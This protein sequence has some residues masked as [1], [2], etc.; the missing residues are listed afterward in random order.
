M[1]STT[2][3]SISSLLLREPAL[4]TEGTGQ[5][6]LLP[7]EVVV[8]LAGV[9]CF[10]SREQSAHGNNPNVAAAGESKKS[11]AKRTSMIASPLIWEIERADEMSMRRY[12]LVI[13]L[14]DK[15]NVK[16]LMEAV[17]CIWFVDH[18]MRFAPSCMHMHNHSKHTFA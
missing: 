18:N 1:S 10:Q 8:G 15:L 11:I 13:S 3:S 5:L 14:I 17:L 12:F 16:R 9:V 6:F 4:T 2:P 7:P